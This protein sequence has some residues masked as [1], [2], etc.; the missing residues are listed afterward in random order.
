V[1]SVAAEEVLSDLTSQEVSEI[2][3]Y[4]L[5][6]NPGATMAEMERQKRN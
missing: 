4:L 1:A 3:A 2:A 6:R 5:H